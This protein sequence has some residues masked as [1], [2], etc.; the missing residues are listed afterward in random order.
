M[1]NTFCFYDDFPYP[2]IIT[3]ELN[4][5]EVAGRIADII[6]LPIPQP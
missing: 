1:K 5:E 6:G 4:P 2:V 3:T